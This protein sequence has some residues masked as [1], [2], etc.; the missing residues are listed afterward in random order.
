MFVII[1]A[2][3]VAAA[4]VL[5]KTE[6]Y[7]GTLLAASAGLFYA[8][9]HFVPLG[10]WVV[11]AFWFAWLAAFVVAILTTSRI[12]F[13]A[14]VA[15]FAIGAILLL[16]SVAFTTT[17]PLA[18]ASENAGGAEAF[19][20]APA[21]TGTTPVSCQ[22]QFVQ[23]WDENEDFKFASNGLWDNPQTKEVSA[24]G[25]SQKQKELAGRDARYLAVASSSV[26]IWGD[27][28]N[29]AP[30]MTA[31]KT[32]LSKEGITLYD[33][34]VAM[35]DGST[36]EI[37]QAPADGINTGSDNGTFVVNANGGITGDLTAVKRT[38]P[39]GRVGYDLVRCA[40]PVLPAAPRGVPTGRTDQTPPKVSPSSPS[41][42]HP[43]TPTQPDVPTSTTPPPV[44]TTMTTPPPVTTTMTTPPPVCEYDSSLP[45]DSPECVKPKDPGENLPGPIGKP[46]APA[47]VGPPETEAP[48]ESAPADPTVTPGAPAPTDVIAPGATQE[49]TPEPTP[50][51]VTSVAPEPSA[52]GTFVPDPDGGNSGN[53]TDTGNAVEDDTQSP[54]VTA[55][56]G[57][58]EDIFPTSGGNRSTIPAAAASLL[59]C[60]GLGL[61]K[62][63]K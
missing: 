42:S 34:L 25:A 14:A 55:P 40:N 31:D 16:P 62:K 3:L 52:P 18:S 30:L 56:V 36:V 2:V 12:G 6:Q 63:R 32:C 57:P 51:P 10:G 9:N 8:V 43:A 15:A 35:W 59:L 45:P 13:P 21:G 61:R 48:I 7:S 26:G 47:P 1:I 60:G 19:A 4:I 23:D 50:D 54:I 5:Y 11:T 38:Y 44:T 37:A 49:P 29:V 27:A 17:N 58:P 46:Q 41:T 28:N 22:S 20:A 53:S 24:D 33:K 39:D